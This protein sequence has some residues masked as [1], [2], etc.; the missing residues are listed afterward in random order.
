MGS[1]DGLHPAIV[2]KMEETVRETQDNTGIILNLA[3]NYGGQAE[4]LFAV[5]EIAKEVE[6]GKLSIEGI[7]AQVFENKLYTKGL[8][9]P[10]LLIRPGGDFRI[11]NFLLWQLA[12]AEIWTTPIF[13]S[14]FTLEVL[15]EALKEYQVR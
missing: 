6:A 2:K 11:S 9:M 10:D 15:I 5:K 3:I 4:I 7:D 8:P 12:Y 14:D 13:W 1:I